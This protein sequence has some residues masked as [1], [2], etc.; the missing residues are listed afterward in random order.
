MK[1]IVFIRILVL[2]ILIVSGGFLNAQYFNDSIVIPAGNRNFSWCSAS[3][4]YIFVSDHVNDS[5]Y[6]ISSYNNL[7]IYLLKNCFI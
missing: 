6:V 1:K 2:T 4:D 3:N 5:I 7:V